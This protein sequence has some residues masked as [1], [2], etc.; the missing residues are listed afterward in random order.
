MVLMV[1]MAYKMAMVK[2]PPLEN[3]ANLL[4]LFTQ[5]AADTADTLPTAMAPGLAVRGPADM[6]AKAAE[7]TVAIS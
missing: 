1:Y 7:E 2:E 3:L 4:A 5:A 6:V